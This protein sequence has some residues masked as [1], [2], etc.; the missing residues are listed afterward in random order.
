MYGCRYAIDRDP[1]AIVDLVHEQQV[2]II[3]EVVLIGKG[4]VEAGDMGKAKEYFCK[5]QQA[6]ANRNLCSHG[7][8]EDQESQQAGER[9]LGEYVPKL[10][11]QAAGSHRIVQYAP[12]EEPAGASQCLT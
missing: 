8:A 11:G 3:A 9:Q 12:E 6:D 10:E 7:P 1:A 4:L 2:D 5:Q